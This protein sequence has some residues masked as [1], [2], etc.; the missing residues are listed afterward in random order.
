MEELQVAKNAN[1]MGTCRV[2]GLCLAVP[3]VINDRRS[4]GA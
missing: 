2:W 4:E 1:R 3:T